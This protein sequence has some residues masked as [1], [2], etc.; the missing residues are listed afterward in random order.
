M[1]KY[2]FFLISICFFTNVLATPTTYKLITPAATGGIADIVARRL[3]EE[4]S[5][6]TG[7]TFIV[8]N[9]PGAGFIVS[10]KAFL[11]ELKTSQNVIL[12]TSTQTKVSAYIT[13][14]EAEIDPNNE[15]KGL[16]ALLK[17]N[18]LL[19]AREDS[20][21]K[22]LTDLNEKVNISYS[23]VVSEAITKYFLP[24]GNYQLVPYKSEV[25]AINAMISNQVDLVSTV[26]FTLRPFNKNLKIFKPF[27]NNISPVNGFSV[28]KNF[29][30]DKLMKLNLAMN[31]VVKDKNFS[32]WIKESSGLEVVGGTP[33]QYDEILDKF[34][35]EFSKTIK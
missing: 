17:M 6:E 24:K 23:S 34:F 18:Y 21:I 26:D 28:A 33:E 19:A 27:P 11:T 4:V 5:K 1:R 30:T 13:N 35:I 31:K 8:I 22:S 16:F 7:D 15:I 25:D 32:S 9:R 3:L 2:I 29:P 14:K 12:F 10:H 20:K